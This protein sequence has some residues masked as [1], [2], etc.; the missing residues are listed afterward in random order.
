MQWVSDSLHD[1]IGLSDETTVQYLVSLARHSTSIQGLTYTLSQ[2]EE[3]LL[4]DSEKSKALAE[5]LHKQ[6]GK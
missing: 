6:Y 4:P 5:R 3:A 2:S 1:I